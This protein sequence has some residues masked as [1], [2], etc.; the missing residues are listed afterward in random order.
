MSKNPQKSRAASADQSDGEVL[1]SSEGID[2][3][4][5]GWADELV[6][7][8]EEGE[9]TQ[10][11]GAVAVAPVITSG[12]FMAQRA[13]AGAIR[14]AYWAVTGQTLSEVR[15]G[16]WAEGSV[17]M[18]FSKH[19]AEIVGRILLQLGVMSAPSPA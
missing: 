2:A 10:D 19:D 12:D 13:A 3:A 15:A 14:A 9:D 6:M 11:S 1:M 8:T 4:A 5:P 18:V 16:E 7:R 17:P